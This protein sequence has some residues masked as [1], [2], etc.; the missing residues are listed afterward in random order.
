MMR[1]RSPAATNTSENW[2]QQ[3]CGGCS[4]GDE[5]DNKSWI[6]AYNSEHS[7]III[8]CSWIINK[9]IV[10]IVDVVGRVGMSSTKEKEDQQGQCDGF[11]QQIFIIWMKFEQQ[12]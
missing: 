8:V 4:D 7:V 1:V 5:D 3:R 2:W 10:V 9:A 6:F 12:L 11:E